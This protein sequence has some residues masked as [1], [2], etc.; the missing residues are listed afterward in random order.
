VTSL[1]RESILNDIRA[2]RFGVLQHAT[3]IDLVEATI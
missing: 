2:V 3:K 1:D